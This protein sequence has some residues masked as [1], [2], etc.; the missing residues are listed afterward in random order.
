MGPLKPHTKASQLDSGQSVR[1]RNVLVVGKNSYV[2]EFLCQHFATQG[3][4]VRAIGSKDCD[5]LNSASVQELF[6][7][8]GG[9]PF[10]IL[11]LA[12]VNKTVDNSYAAFRDNVQMAWNLVSGVRPVNVESL[13]YLSSVDVYGRSPKLPMTETTSLDPDT[14]YGLSKSTSEWIVREELG[15]KCPT[16]ILRLPGIFARSRNDRSVIGRLIST[17]QKDGKACIHGDGQVL[18]DYVFAPDLCRAVEC[19]VARRASGTFNLATGKSVSLLQILDVIRESLGIDF[20][21][22]HLPADK[23]RNFD[24]RYDTAKLSAA[25]GEFDFT[26]LSAA[27]RSYL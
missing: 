11:F 25:L 21:V 6:A 10:T 26:P 9:K 27:I 23:E 1:D 18:R 5:F 3:A 14:W 24:M 13:I 16:C 12:V 4:S 19:L 20:G 22:V 8:F 17:I 2:G 15:S 7:S